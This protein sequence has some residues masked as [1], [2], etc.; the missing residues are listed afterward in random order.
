MS[1]KP[2][3]YVALGSA[4]LASAPGVVLAACSSAATPASLAAFDAD[5]A[6]WLSKN[7]GASDLG[8]QVQALAAAAVNSGDKNFGSSLGS[9][10]G[11]ASSDQGKAIGTSLKGL[12]GSCSDPTDPGDA[13]DKKYIS[14][15]IAPNL[16]T[17]TAANTAFGDTSQTAA[18]GGGGGA[19]GGG[20]GSGTAATGT[21]L[22]GGGS[23][24]AG[25]AP[26][27]GT[28]QTSFSPTQ[29]T[30]SGSFGAVP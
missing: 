3:L 20:A 2:L 8:A 29:G 23:N 6:G 30:G 4:F 7:G 13:S 5:P 25:G 12:G 9:M 15:Y 28:T 24:G 26:T 21:G 11:K 14:T 10:L 16:L 18:V 1:I 17:N 27:G 22:P 19:A